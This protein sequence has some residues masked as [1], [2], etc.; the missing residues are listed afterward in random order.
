MRDLWLGKPLKFLLGALLVL[1]MTGTAFA[2]EVNHYGVRLRGL[3]VIPDQTVDSRLDNLE[4]EAKTAVAPELDLEYFFTRNI[5]TELI[6]GVT[7]HDLIA[8][9]RSLGSTWLLPPTLTLKYHP[10]PAAKISPYIGFGVN[11]VIPFND[12]ADGVLNVSDFH[13]S[14]SFGWAAQA[15][16]DVP[17]GNNWFF[18]LDL[19]YLNVDTEARING[20]TYDLDLNPFIVGT[21]VGYRF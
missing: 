11:Y 5:S 8:Q 19:K 6:L 15:G 18:N 14:S 10:L 9:G 21:G 4:I 13:I 16:A 1:A 3:V 20:T 17:L 2:E 12:K 7:K